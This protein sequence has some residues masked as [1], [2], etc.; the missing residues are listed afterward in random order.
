MSLRKID[1]GSLSYIDPL[2]GKEEV[3]A[4]FHS[5]VNASVFLSK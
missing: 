1:P 3:G 2:L 5:A 4:P